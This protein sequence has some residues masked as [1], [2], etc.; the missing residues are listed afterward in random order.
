M[1]VEKKSKRKQ[2]RKKGFTLVELIVAICIM[3]ILLIIAIPEVQKIQAANKE[4]K[5]EA[6]EKSMVASSK[7]YID[8]YAKDLFGNNNSGCIRI[9]YSDL[10]GKNLV[11]D[12]SSKNIDC[13]NDN[14][15]YLEVRKVLDE[16]KYKIN[17]VCKDTERNKQVYKIQEITGP[18]G[19]CSLEPDLEA[20]KI[21]VTPANSNNTWYNAK[22]LAVK[23][24]VSD[25]SGLNS[26]IA[27][28]YDW[29][30]QT[31]GTTT[32]NDSYNYKNKKGI[33]QV[34]YTIPTAKMPS[35]GGGKYKLTVTPDT[36]KGNGVQDA[37]GNK[38]LTST[39]AKEYWID[40]QA[41]ILSGSVTSTDS[42]FQSK[43]VKVNLTAS[44]NFTP[45]SSLKVYISNTGYQTGG[46]WR[47][48]STSMDWTLSG[49]YD[50]GR[51]TVY[52]TIKDLAGNTTS[53]SFPYTIYSQC[54]SKV[55]DGYWYDTG[56]CNRSCG[57]GTKPQR[58]DQKDAYLSGVSCGSRTGT[59]QCNTQSCCS[60][61]N[62]YDGS[63]C[64]ASCNGGTKNLVAYSY[65]DGSRC[66]SQDLPS[67]GTS[68][69]TRDCCE[70]V[71]YQDGASCTAVCGGGTRN[72]LAYS[73]YNNTRC[74]SKDKG[75]GGSSCNNQGCCDSVYYIDGSTCN[76]KC[77][78]G[79]KNQ[80][81]YS[82][83]TNNR[84][85]SKDKSSGGSSCNSQNCCDK[86][87]YKDGN[88]CSKTCGG[89]TKNQLAYSYYDNSIRCSGKD[90]T[91]GGKAC[92]TQSC[93]KTMYTCRYANPCNEWPNMVSGSTEW[94]PGKN[95]NWGGTYGSGT[96]VQVEDAGDGW[97]KEVGRERYIL[98]GCLSSTKSCCNP[99][100][101]QG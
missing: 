86:V 100:S 15:T 12:F 62:Y 20:P 28:K 96:A 92:N 90:K 74:P 7:L 14:E 9:K 69:N 97:Y 49:S 46:S 41:P 85:S 51:R 81:A 1:G 101:C 61:V 89:G 82:T 39:E 48:Y 58:I 83:Y 25:V 32:V 42:R 23:I 72:Q 13:G 40:N 80:L 99:S 43:S 77:G 11:K 5:Y 93:A 6:Y 2:I 17:M 45:T 50:G 35:D 27:V 53:R 55:D 30:N 60:K 54:S 88:S 66:S 10:K 47:N 16:Y 84:C 75:S 4:R 98:K 44:D 68:C 26:N 63:S 65:Y 33:E 56:S 52:V 21:T 87:I 18:E 37:L 29:Y 71:Y 76:K 8:S 24:K 36:S 31:T 78:G 64:S 70:S 57:G 91:S 38:T 67:G 59:A 19:S 73:N 79:T 3:G 95:F 94:H 34:S 22:N